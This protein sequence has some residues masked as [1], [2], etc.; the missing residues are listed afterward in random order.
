[1]K[2]DLV[3]PIIFCGAIWGLI[4]A[5]LGYVLHSIPL[6]VGWFFWF[7]L[8]FFFVEKAYKET[9]KLS[10]ILYTAGV[11]ASIKLI[12]LLMPTRLD[13]VLN[14]AMSIL[15]EGLVVFAA[16][17][18]IERRKEL[19]KFKYVEALSVSVGWRVL[20]LVYIL[21]MPPFYF[22]VS[23]FRALEP[24]RKFF[25]TESL[26]NSVIIFAYLTI[27]ERIRARS[28]AKYG[29][30]ECTSW[31]PAFWVQ[32]PLLRMSLSFFALAL[33]LFAQWVL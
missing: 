32:N 10:S 19:A 26:T 11:A 12:N 6:K 28:E 13:R 30:E 20:Y 4:E 7:P 17:A 14:P 25:L 3:S 27:A 9:G 33:A 23:P 16:F 21:L 18:L 22:S 29:S 1:M 2:K 31:K 24:F 8:A 5:T 15:L